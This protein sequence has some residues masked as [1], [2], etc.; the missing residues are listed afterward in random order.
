M[1]AYIRQSTFSDGDTIFASLLNNEFDQLLAAF[2]VSTGHTHDGS[3]TGDGGPISKLFSNAITFG[4]NENTD[5]AVTFDGSSNDG[6]ITW[7]EDE[8]YFQYS[9]DILLSTTEKVLFRDSAIYINSSTDGQLDI[10]AD[11]EVQ[12]AATTVD[13]NAN[14]DVS[15]TLTYGSLSDGAITIT[16]FVDEDDMTSNSATLV[17][18]QQ[19]VKAYVDAQLTASDL[20]FQG[21]SGGALSIDLDSETLDIAGGTGI[22]TSGSGNTLTVAIDSTVATL[23]GSQTLTNKILTSPVLNTG[24]SG[25]AILDEDDFA[26]D[27]ATKLATQQSIK[28]YIATQVAASDTLAELSDTNISTPSSGQILIYD[29]SDSFDNKSLSGDVTISSTGATT[30][31]S[32]AVE[33]AMLNANVITGQTAL[34][35]G[36]D[37]AND[38]LLI[39]DAD[40]GLKKISL[41]NVT[42]ATGG[43]SD[44]VSDTTPQ[45]GGALDVNGN[46]IVSASNGNI[47]ITPN[48]SGKVILDGLSHPTSDGSAG[49]FLKTDGGGNLAFATVTTDLSGDSTPQLGGNLDVNGNSIVSASNGNIAITPNGSGK[50]ILDGLSHPTSDGSNG[51]VLTTDGAGNLSFT[52]KTVDTTNLVDDTTP[53]LGGDLDINGNTIVSTSNGNIAIT[54]NGSGKVILDGLS[55][56]TAD[57]SN[58]QFLKTDGGGTLSFA[59]VTQATGN[60]LENLSE[61]TSP[62]LGGNLD[63]NGNDIVSTSNAN[64]DI[65]PNGS[66]VIN[67]DGNGSSGGVSVSDGLIDIRT[68]TGNV[69]KVKFYCESSNAHAQTLQ[70]APHSAASSAVLV[71]PTASG[72]LVGT[73][74]TGSVSNTMLGGSIADSKLSTISTANKV[75]L[76]A[77]DIDGAT[78]IGA[79]L[80]T[81]D[82]IAVDDGAGGTNRKAALSRVVTLV[83]DNASFSSQGFATAM[84]IAL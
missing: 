7:M 72:T 43:I 24:V 28:A 21:D 80:S 18:T 62:Q 70:A 13:I 66:G 74:D 11:T 55:H 35:S 46:A 61:D 78:D 57:G 76:A 59:S 20:D 65:L 52:S 53:Q 1:A 31:G 10:V 30:I 34:T 22:D 75:S 47:S 29:G 77:V 40:A 48:G 36:F 8:D 64:I 38:H 67:L 17:P 2:N 49:Q 25:T 45:L 60:E 37:T 58:G 41:A 6:V 14:A 71:L 79:A 26:S 5:I 81:S 54:P 39:H 15:G 33:T 50:V 83:E 19:S 42:S 73:G 51:Q 44:V 16:A 4:K 84:A 27:S 56:P 3:T 69:A 68:G 12:I 82:L 32:G 23:T 63:V 9:D